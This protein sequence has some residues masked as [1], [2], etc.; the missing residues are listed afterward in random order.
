[1]KI[2]LNG[3]IIDADEARIDPADRGLLLGD[4]LFETFRVTST[5]AQ[6]VG[7]HLR[8][9]KF[10]CSILKMPYP[11]GIETSLRDVI[12]ANKIFN[13][14]LRLTVT[15]GAAP[16]GVLPPTNVSTTVMISAIVTNVPS[17]KSIKAIIAKSTRRNELSPLSCC[18]S[19]NYLDNILAQQEADTLGADEALLRN[20]IGNIAEATASN[21]FFVIEGRLVTP[22]IL[23]GALPGV[24]REEILE[25]AEEQTLGVQDIA[26]ASEAFLT[27]SLGVNPLISI[28]NTLVGSGEVGPLTK[29]YL[30]K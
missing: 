7:P 25:D 11:H 28:D 9:L 23:D 27:N 16:R 3:L 2:Y 21:V 30:D 17:K 24:V 13:G 22:P 6:R 12:S 18:K 10:G 19:L 8:R 29:K 4:G 20:T 1:M 14:S 26:V 15:R 5:K